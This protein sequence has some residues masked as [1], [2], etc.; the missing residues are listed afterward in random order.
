[1]TLRE[2]LADPSRTLPETLGYFRQVASALARAHSKGIIHCDLKPDNVMVAHD[3]LVKVLDFGLVRQVEGHR[4]EPAAAPSAAA[5][6]GPNERIRIEGTIGYMS[7]E[8]AAGEPLDARSDVFSFG[9]MLFEAI[10]GKLPFWHES[11]V[12]SLHSLIHDPAPPL[13]RVSPTVPV[14]L[15]QLVDAC[16]TKEAALRPSSMDEVSRRLQSIAQ[17]KP[18]AAKLWLWGAAAAVIVLASIVAVL[19]PWRGPSGV[20]IAVIPFSSGQSS[21]ESAFLAE[22]ISEGLIVALAQLPDLKVISRNSSFRFAGPSL[23]VQQV[24]RT[25]G[26]RALVTGRIVELGGRMRVNAELVSADGT[27]IWGAEYNPS[28]TN[29][30]DVQ[31]QIATDVAR[32]VRSGL[33]DADQR[34]LTKPI[35]PNSDVYALLLQGRYQMWLYTPESTRKAAGYFE[36]AL[37]IDPGYDVANAELANAYRRLAGAGILQPAE[38]IPLAEQAASKAIAA[39]DESVEA[40]SALADIRRDQWDWETAEPEYRRAIALSP[41]FVP[42]RQGLAIGLSVRGQDEAAVAE[43]AK[44]REL[45]PVGLSSA[46]DSAAVFYNVRRF[47]GALQIL[48]EALSRDGLAPAVWTWI[49]IASGGAG[50]FDQAITA[51]EKAMQLG[52]RT[53]ATLCYYVHALARTGRRDDA[54]RFMRTVESAAF[55]PASSLAIAF[56]GLGE[57]DRAIEQLQK[58]LAARDP[59]LQYI[60]VESYLNPLKT[61]ARFQAVVAGMKPLPR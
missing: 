16:L 17:S 48:Q 24:A 41:S 18:S 38:A 50:R 31:S 21:G 56:V 40:H 42:A 49:G 29:L 47:D 4:R 60:P 39:D 13:A 2:K 33:T 46:I 61:D 32:Q 11:I 44:V 15:R 58:A 12:Q 51:F 8:Q 28:L 59:L 34:K 1:M 23:D 22:G 30:A 3:G 19:R 6:T 25:L 54:M 9:C 36:Q 26:V 43:I 55:V 45:D 7:P 10:T 35:H 52:D 57:N 20:A 53:P 5:P 27:A 37:G 14:T